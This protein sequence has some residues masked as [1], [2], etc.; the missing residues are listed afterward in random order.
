MIP[1]SPLSKAAIFARGTVL[2][3]LKIN[4]DSSQTPGSTRKLAT[5]LCTHNWR[6]STGIWQRRQVLLH[7]WILFT[8]NNILKFG[9]TVVSTQ[10][11]VPCGDSAAH[12]ATDILQSEAFERWL[13]PNK[14]E[15][16][17]HSFGPRWLGGS[18]KGWPKQ[19]TTALSSS[20]VGCEPHLTS[21]AH[22]PLAFHGQPLS[23]G[24]KQKSKW[25]SLKTIQ[26]LWRESISWLSLALKSLAS[27]VLL[28]R[29]LNPLRCTPSAAPE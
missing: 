24:S 28:H 3:C 9:D 26:K 10:L 4:W 22:Q 16:L 27:L 23:Y 14:L 8:D 13:A 11:C 15:E 2:Y 29:R 6:I 20:E 5:L 18:V 17:V 12:K 1:C 21:I 25:G 19:K 7:S